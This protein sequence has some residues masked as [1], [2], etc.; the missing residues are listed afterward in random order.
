MSIHADPALVITDGGLAGLLA[1]FIEG[2]CKPAATLDPAADSAGARRAA[3]SAAWLGLASDQFGQREWRRAAAMRAA[4][5]CHLGELV[6]SADAGTPARTTQSAGSDRTRLLLSAGAEAV[7]RGL[8]RVVWPIHLGG[9]KGVGVT[10]TG[11]AGRS[12]LDDIIDAC[13]RAA[14]TARLVSIDAPPE[15][16]GLVIQTPFVDFSDEQLADLAADVDLPIES[17]FFG[18]TDTERDRWRAALASAGL[19]MPAV[20]HHGLTPT[21]QA[22]ATGLARAAAR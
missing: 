4:Q 10:G 9:A 20:N 19:P 8:A 1:C 18:T 21:V 14:V 22:A 17:A 3:R 13:D 6:D 5:V 7:R 2:V 15:S 16:E 12:R 11:D